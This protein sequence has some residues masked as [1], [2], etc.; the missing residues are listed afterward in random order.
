MVRT[1]T[2]AKANMDAQHRKTY[3]GMAWTS[4]SEMSSRTKMNFLSLLMTFRARS[5]LS[6]LT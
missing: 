5:Q 1:P 2:E 6:V 4:H 3:I